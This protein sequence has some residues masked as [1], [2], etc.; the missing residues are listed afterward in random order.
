MKQFKKWSARFS[1][2]DENIGLGS[3]IETGYGARYM[4]IHIEGGWYT[5][6]RLR[7]NRQYLIR[8]TKRLWGGDMTH[9]FVVRYP[10]V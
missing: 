9:F 3:V 10:T 4:I 1:V 5:L 2:E 8:L 6:V 7:Q